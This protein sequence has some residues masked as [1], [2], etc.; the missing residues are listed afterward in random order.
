MSCHVPEDLSMIDHLD[1]S[2]SKLELWIEEIVQRNL[3]N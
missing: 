1:Q 3:K 2:F